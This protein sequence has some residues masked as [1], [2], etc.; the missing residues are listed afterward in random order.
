M[1]KKIILLTLLSVIISSEFDI[2]RNEIES[3]FTADSVNTNSSNEI[4][5]E[6][7]NFLNDKDLQLDDMELSS[8]DYEIYGE[9]EKFL[10]RYYKENFLEGTSLRQMK[11][12]IYTIMGSAIP[13]S[14]S[15]G[16]LG[17]RFNI[18][19]N[20]GFRL[21]IPKKVY[22][23]NFI[24]SVSTDVFFTTLPAAQEYQQGD[25]KLSNIFGMLNLD[26]GN[27]GIRGGFG[28]SPSSIYKD[29]EVIPSIPFDLTYKIKISNRFDFLIALHFQETLGWPGSTMGATSEIF[30]I[31]AHFGYPITISY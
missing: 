28:L 18:G 21:D 22:I 9:Y 24:L 23:N 1:N 7:D 13:F 6:K 17:D 30:G 20:F 8:V 12:A 16:G 2:K 3:L 31:N 29:S 11:I 5:L 14:I 26:I 15:E 4:N 25:Y 10:Q 27:F 19:G